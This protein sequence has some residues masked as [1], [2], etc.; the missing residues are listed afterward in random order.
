MKNFFLKCKNIIASIGKYLLKFFSSDPVASTT[1]V[2]FVGS[3]IIGW[4]IIL[5]HMGTF[6]DNDVNVIGILLGGGATPKIAGS[7]ADA[8][9][10]LRSSPSSPPVPPQN[11]ET[12][13]TGDLK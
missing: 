4:I 5:K 8:L 12:S 9:C 2:I 3:A 7:I 10:T 1:R 13:P 6:T 11:I